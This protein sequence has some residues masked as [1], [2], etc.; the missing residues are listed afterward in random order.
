MASLGAE[1][2]SSPQASSDGIDTTP[3]AAAGARESPWIPGPLVRLLE[4][5]QS[6]QDMLVLS[7]IRPRIAKSKFDG[8]FTSLTAGKA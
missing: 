2:E 1:T 5:S 4:R 8:V 7:E 6:R 3:S